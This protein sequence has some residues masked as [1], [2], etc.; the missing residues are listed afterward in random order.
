MNRRGL[1]CAMGLRK[2]LYKG[3]GCASRCAGE[4]TVEAGWAGD[5][6]FQAQARCSPT[7]PQTLRAYVVMPSAQSKRRATL[8]IVRRNGAAGP[9]T[10]VLCSRRTGA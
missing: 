1:G 4:G 10:R 6:R 8:C 5:V 7:L 3:R 9:S 2:G